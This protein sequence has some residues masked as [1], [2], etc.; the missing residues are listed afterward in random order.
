MSG[1]LAHDRLGEG[2]PLVLI[3]GLGGTRRIWHP[4]LA[5]L[6]RDREVIAV[7]MPGFGDSP[8]LPPGSPATAAALGEAVAA[9]M[10]ELGIESADLAGNSLGGWVAL[11][12]ARAGRARSLCLISPAGLWRHP[13]GPRSYDVRALAAR[14]RPVLPMIVRSGRIRNRMLAGTVGRPELVPPA[15]ALAMIGSWLD[16]AGYEAANEQMRAAVFERPES[17]EVPTTIAWGELDRLVAPPRPE[18][19]PPR[20]RF[21]VLP[22]CG[23]TPNWDDPELITRLLLETTEAAEASGLEAG[24]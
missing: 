19:R 22:G 12:M 9:T 5:A 2:P 13:L 17:I 15:E 24:A 18:R 4:Q 3:H 11:E 16:A 23:H 21:V 8:A 1:T 10:D 7:D 6:A 20:S 14:L